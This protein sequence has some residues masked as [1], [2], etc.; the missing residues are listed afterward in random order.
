MQVSS[1]SSQNLAAQLTGT[2]SI[3]INLQPDRIA[4]MQADVARAPDIARRVLGKVPLV[5]LSASTAHRQIDTAANSAL[6]SVQVRT[7]AA[8]DLRAM[9]TPVLGFLVTAAGEEQRYE[10]GYCHH[11]KTYVQGESAAR[12]RG[13]A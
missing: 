12:A 1:L 10:Y 5:A 7:A 8:R 11:A 13:N 6:T 9:P 3:G 2:Q 4:A